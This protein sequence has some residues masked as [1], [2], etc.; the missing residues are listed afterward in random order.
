MDVQT[1]PR[2][3]KS[4]TLYLRL[5]FFVVDPLLLRSLENVPNPSAAEDASSLAA[6]LSLKVC[7]FSE[8]GR[9]ASNSRVP[10]LGPATLAKESKYASRWR[11]NL[12]VL[13]RRMRLG[14]LRLGTKGDVDD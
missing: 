5:F 4:D 8:E 11:E 13:A 10:L 9:H 1:T 12:L 7:N 2:G 6:G 14:E 3:P